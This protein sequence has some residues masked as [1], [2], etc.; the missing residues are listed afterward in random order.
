MHRHLHILQMFHRTTEQDLIIDP[1]F[2]FM[3]HQK[4]LGNR[5]KL[6]IQICIFIKDAHA[7]VSCGTSVVAGLTTGFAA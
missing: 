1:P 4:R 7:H 2:T 3:P 6:F 5:Q